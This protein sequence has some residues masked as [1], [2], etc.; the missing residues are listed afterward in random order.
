[1]LLDEVACV[2]RYRLQGRSVD[3]LI[4]NLWY[5]TAGNAI[6][7]VLNLGFFASLGCYGSL[8]RIDAAFNGNFSIFSNGERERVVALDGSDELTISE[9]LKR[10]SNEVHLGKAIYDHN[11]LRTRSGG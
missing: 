1:M 6:E 5:E 10:P 2:S 7:V 4:H 9:H 11:A 8:A 3:Y